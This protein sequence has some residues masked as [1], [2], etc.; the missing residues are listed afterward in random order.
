MDIDPFRE[1]TEDFLQDLFNAIGVPVL[2]VDETLR[3]RHA[4]AATQELCG[5]EEGSPL[6]RR[7]GEVLQ[8]FFECRSARRCGD[9]AGCAACRLR[10]MV[11]ATFAQRR[12][13]RETVPLHVLQEGREREI[14]MQ[15]DA[16]PITRNNRLYAVLTLKE[17]TELMRLRRIIP[18]CT[19]CNKIRND[20]NYWMQLEQYFHEH[21]NMDLSHGICPDCLKLLYPDYADDIRRRESG[22]GD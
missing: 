22:A 6:Q 14:W 4:N 13:Q 19:Q 8:C 15:V 17:A 5:P 3:I 9:T 21:E 11:G 18:I 20:Q 12:A 1:F 16:A 7:C 2:V 10:R